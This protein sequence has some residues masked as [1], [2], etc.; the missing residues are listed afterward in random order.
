MISFKMYA[1]IKHKC[2]SA[3]LPGGRKNPV[4]EMRMVHF[5]QLSQLGFDY[6]VNTNYSTFVYLA[7]RTASSKDL[8]CR[9]ARPKKF[10]CSVSQ[11]NF[12]FQTVASKTAKKVKPLYTFLQNFL[13][14][15]T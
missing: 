6:S 14:L 5:S 9:S 10:M 15:F 13:F 1:L 11:A 12:S 8:R 4:V 2:L 7:T 3:D